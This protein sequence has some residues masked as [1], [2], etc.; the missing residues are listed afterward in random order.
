MHFLL[1]WQGNVIQ[2]NLVHSLDVISTL[3]EYQIWGLVMEG[4]GTATF[5]N[6]MVRLGLN[7][8]GSSITT[9]FSIVGIRDKAGATANYCFNSVYIGGTGVTSASNTFA[10]LSD[11]VDNTRKFRD[12]I[13]YNARSN[14]SGGIA[15]V[16]VQVGGSAP[17]PA[18]L[19]SNYNDL[20]AT[21]TDGVIGV[22]NSIIQPTLSDWQIAT[23]QEANGISADPQYL[24]PDGNA[25]TVDLHINDTSPCAGASVGI[26]GIT[27]DFDGDPRLN[28]PS[29]G[30][31]EPGIPSATPAPTPT[32]TVAPRH[33]PTPRSRT[34]PAP[35]PNATPL[36]STSA[37]PI[38]KPLA[39]PAGIRRR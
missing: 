38:T 24:D 2:Q 34:T 18:G 4:Q 35:R 1:P 21:G 23:G 3:T 15:N 26:A 27:D 28:L 29:I 22:F 9:G 12:N 8:T 5:Q 14:V 11:V 19:T 36:T 37:G 16:A 32:P 31:D 13:F 33:T 30:A 39:S 10:F 7:A 17:N 20:Y 25:A 6:N